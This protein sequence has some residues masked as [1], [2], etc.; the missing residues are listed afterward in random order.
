[1]TAARDAMFRAVESAWSSGSSTQWR[2]DNPATGQCSVT[3]LLLRDLLGGH[4]LKTRVGAAWHYYNA[5]DGQRLDLTASQFSAPIRYDDVETD[6]MDAMSDTSAA[7][8]DALRT[9]T[10]EALGR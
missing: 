8:L 3:A 5:F 9:A 2:R 10:L 1:M 4:I 7:Q 6:R